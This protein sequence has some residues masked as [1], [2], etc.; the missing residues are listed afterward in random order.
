MVERQRRIQELEQKLAVREEEIAQL[1]HI[2]GVVESNVTREADKLHSEEFNLYESY[3]KLRIE[4]VK[5]RDLAADLEVEK[6]KTIARY[7]EEKE[8]IIADL[9]AEIARLKDD[10]NGSQEIVSLK[11]RLVRREAEIMSLSMQLNAKLKLYPPHH[12]TTHEPDT[13]QLHA[14]LPHV[15]S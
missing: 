13:R 9:E 2:L 8:S 10:L 3:N 1:K 5:L 15:R 4:V 14:T 12:T 6:T 7:T 11:E